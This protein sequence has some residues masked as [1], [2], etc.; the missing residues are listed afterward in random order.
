MAT[1]KEGSEARLMR[2]TATAAGK[3]RMRITPGWW[4]ARGGGTDRRRVAR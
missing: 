3:K 2:Q 4:L 1:E